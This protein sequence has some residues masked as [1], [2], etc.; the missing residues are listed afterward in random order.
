[1]IREN[2]KERAYD[3]FEQELQIGDKVIACVHQTASRHILYKAE[4]IGWSKKR[5]KLAILESATN[6]NY[7]D[8]PRAGAW[9]SKTGTFG[10]YNSDRIYKI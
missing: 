6:S 4:V 7:V 10:D 3:A 8:G 1:M 9:W 5:V 2:T